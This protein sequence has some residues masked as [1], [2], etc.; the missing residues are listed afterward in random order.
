MNKFKII[1]PTQNSYKVIGRLIKSIKDQT[2]N[3]WSVI[4]VD[5]KS[6]K[7]H[8]NFLKELCYKDK[9]FSYLKQNHKN[10]GIFG[11]MNQGLENLD[12]NS[13]I[14]FWGSDDWAF[15]KN[16]F[17]D[18]N[19]HLNKLSHLKI[20]LL[21]CKG[22]YFRMNGDFFKDTSFAK[23][24][25]NKNITLSE[26]KKLLFFGLTPP[27][28]STLMHSSLFS[29][30]F[31]Y[32]DNYLLTGDLDFFC[33]LSK[34]KYLSAYLLDFFLVSMSCGGISSRNHLKRFN[35]VIKSYSN[36]SKKLYIIPFF[37]RYFLKIFKLS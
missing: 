4:F 17:K 25:K 34:K 29:P 27:H 23:K 7:K 11:A 28:Q 37:L 16:T 26:Y 32:D 2:Y 36:L 35:E 19:N 12:K 8:I 21:I 22:K 30:S 33:R 14:L 6:N 15:G 1:V 24:I 20:D 18:M 13:W 10:K 9:R 31:K 5:G 3:N